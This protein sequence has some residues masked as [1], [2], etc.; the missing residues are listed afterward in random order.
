M[1]WK[2]YVLMCE[3][4]KRDLLKLF[5]EWGRRNKGERQCG[6]IQLWFSI[7]TFVNITMCPQYNNNTIKQEKKPT[8]WKVSVLVPNFQS[9][10]KRV[11]ER[12]ISTPSIKWVT[13]TR[14]QLNNKMIWLCL[15]NYLGKNEVTIYINDWF[16]H[17]KKESFR[18][19]W[20]IQIYSLNLFTVLQIKGFQ[21]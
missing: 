18:I 14:F 8:N 20:Q 11:P 10:A 2:F 13:Q 15:K 16:A 17:S 1:W 3:M 6:W 21:K 5:Q 9:L 7:R 4:E 19:L 12:K